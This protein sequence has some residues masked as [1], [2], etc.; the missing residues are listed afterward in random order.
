MWFDGAV[1]I[2]IDLASMMTRSG[3]S[4]SSAPARAARGSRVA[5]V[6]LAAHPGSPAGGAA[7]APVPLPPVRPLE[8]RTIPPPPPVPEP[9]VEAA[10]ERQDQPPTA[11]Q[12]CIA[13]LAALG[14][15]AEASATPKAG[16]GACA[17]DAPVRLKALK[18]VDAER[19]IEFPAQPIV[20]CRFAEPLGRW[21]TSIVDPV[22]RARLG[23]DVT[24]VRTGPGFECRNRNRASAGKLSAHGL[25]LAL[26]ISDFALSQNGTLPVAPTRDARGNE[27]V[28]A[29]RTAACGWFTTVLG[30]GSDDAHADH[31]HLDIE[32][33]GSS[34]RYRICR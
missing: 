22:V 2:I 16:N 14:F 20:S 21:L 28:A 33:H 9:K 19:R 10:P 31:L 11:A 5:I 17:I 24:A 18:A 8:L 6:L 12:D 3:A 29:I 23:A 32:R 27:V 26:D 25:G 30:P 13:R 34:E 7:A 1:R 4:F 15:D